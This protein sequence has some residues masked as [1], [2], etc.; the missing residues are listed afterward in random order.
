MGQGQG[1]CLDFVCF[2]KINDIRSLWIMYT[3]GAVQPKGNGIQSVSER[4][5]YDI[6]LFFIGGAM[7]KKIEQISESVYIW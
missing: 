4:T 3:M 5:G 6:V 1:N 2:K 7:R